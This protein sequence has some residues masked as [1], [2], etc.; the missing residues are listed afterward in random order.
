MEG[1]II[2]IWSIKKNYGTST[3]SII[4]ALLLAKELQ[5]KRVLWCTTNNFFGI[6]RRSLNLKVNSENSIDSLIDLFEIDKE[7][8]NYN[9]KL[10][11]QATIKVKDKG[12][13]NL[14][15]LLESRKKE[16]N[17][18][19]ENLKNIFEIVIPN[20]KSYF[21]Y[22]VIDTSSFIKSN[23][24]KRII[25]ESSL[26]VN[27]LQQNSVAIEE[28]VNLR[29]LKYIELPKKIINILNNYDNRIRPDLEIIEKDIGENF[30][31]IKKYINLCTSCNTGNIIQYANDEVEDDIKDYI[32][33][34]LEKLGVELIEE[35][36]NDKVTLV[37]RIKG[38]FGIG[39]S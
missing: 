34:I 14:Y 1:K 22:I 23:V 9:E 18:I 13:D 20:L 2:S 21:D 31:T 27:V 38:V 15:F 12:Y 11:E 10:I 7:K 39:E 37:S 16:K 28:Y 29:D 36:F 32:N 26:L 8:E 5:D 30:L 4:T 24:T 25:E 19:E 3:I 35:D 33:N 6:A 17:Y